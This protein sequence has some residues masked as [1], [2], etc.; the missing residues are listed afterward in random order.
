M[1]D[2]CVMCGAPASRDYDSEEFLCSVCRDEKNEI[3][4][5][6]VYREDAELE[7]MYQEYMEESFHGSDEGDL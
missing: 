5:E 1:E 4:A 3:E 2:R 6:M 7:A